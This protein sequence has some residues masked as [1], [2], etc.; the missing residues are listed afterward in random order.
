[1]VIV[2]TD[3]KI[4]QSKNREKELHKKG[5]NL[6]VQSSSKST[7]QKGQGCPTGVKSATAVISAGRKSQRRNVAQHKITS[8]CYRTPAAED[9]VT[10]SASEGNLTGTV[11]LVLK[12][13][14]CFPA[15]AQGRNKTDPDPA[16]NKSSKTGL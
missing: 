6:D 8:R 16:S 9:S 7:P 14:I 11:P 1:M 2:K 12:S 10:V 3:N 13:A 5:S 15:P 4:V